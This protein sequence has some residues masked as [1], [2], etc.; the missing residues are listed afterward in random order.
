MLQYDPIGENNTPKK[1]ATEIKNNT[2]YNPVFFLV[3]SIFI[4]FCKYK[5]ELFN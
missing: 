1:T 3:D 2:Q 4:I 5:A